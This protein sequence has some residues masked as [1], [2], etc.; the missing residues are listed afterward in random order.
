MHYTLVVIFR[1]IKSQVCSF[2]Y[3]L[4]LL[5]GGVDENID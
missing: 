2:V 5:I 4:S 3:L 1:I